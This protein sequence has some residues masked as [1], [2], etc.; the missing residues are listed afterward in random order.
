MHLTVTSVLGKKISVSAERWKLIID[1]KHPEIK[2]KEDEVQKALMDPDEVRLSK[3][4]PDVFLYY[5]TQGKL[6]LCVVAKHQNEDGFIITIYFT[7]KIKEG[8]EIFR[9]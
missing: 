9:R 7:D 2:G 3:S 4:D 1:T 6:S 8:T 5:K